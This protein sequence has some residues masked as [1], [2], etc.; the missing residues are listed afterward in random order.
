LPAVETP[1]KSASFA[2]RDTAAV[3]IDRRFSLFAEVEETP[4]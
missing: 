1:P 2:L 3:A 4:K